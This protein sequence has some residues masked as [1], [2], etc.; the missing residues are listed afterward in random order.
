MRFDAK[1]CSR[2]KALRAAKALAIRFGDRVIEIEVQ[3]DLESALEQ[4]LTNWFSL[5]ELGRALLQFSP[6]IAQVLSRETWL[7]ALNVNPREWGTDKMREYGTDPASVVG[8]L[9]LENSAGAGEPGNSPLR[10]CYNAAFYNA[11]DTNQTLAQQLHDGA[12]EVLGGAMG[13]WREPTTLER[14]GVAS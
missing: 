4:R 8:L 3:V 13:E 11:M 5:I 6:G 1:N 7:R 9:N 2:I 14:C 12:N 10:H